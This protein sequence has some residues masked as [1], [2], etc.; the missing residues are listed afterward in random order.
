MS[1]EVVASLRYGR[2]FGSGGVLSNAPIF[3]VFPAIHAGQ[4]SEAQGAATIETAATVVATAFFT[5][6]SIWRSINVVLSAIVAQ[7]PTAF[8]HDKGIPIQF[9]KP[10][11]SGATIKLCILCVKL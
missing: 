2:M 3:K 8:F 6:A 9:Y 10:V 7:S 4:R 11:I 1:R 5:A